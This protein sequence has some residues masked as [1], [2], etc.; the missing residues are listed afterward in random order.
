MHKNSL[1]GAIMLLTASIV[2]GFAFVFQN[3]TIGYLDA[4]TVNALRCLIAAAFLVPVLLIKAKIK[5][6]K[7][8]K[9]NKAQKKDLL[10]AGV[11]CG[12][13]LCLAMNIQQF[14]MILYPSD[15]AVS[16]RSGFIT[17]LYVVFVPIISLIFKQRLRITVIISVILATLGMFL[18]C[19][20]KGF[21]KVYIGDLIV[22]ISAIGFA[23][24]IIVIDRYSD[25]VDGVKLSIIE[26]LICGFISLILMF[27][28]EKPSFE[29]I[30]KVMGPILYLGIVSSGVGYTLQIIGQQYSKNPTL[31]SIIMSFEAVFAAIGGHLIL[32][33]HLS[34]IE[35]IG[36]LVML[37]SIIIGQL[38]EN[39][40]IYL[41]KPKQDEK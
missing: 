39:P 8:I 31:D 15:A 20:S 9:E 13:F 28:F 3:K 6:E 4:F 41:R 23:L 36:C 2:W 14:G 7:V 19:F 33:Q 40:L 25:R 35:I 18:L 10:I 22:L 21:D 37:V 32:S 16:G 38:N 24:Q 1:K 11:L 12:L 34:F 5:K 27:I 26:F 17:A 30:S 29:N